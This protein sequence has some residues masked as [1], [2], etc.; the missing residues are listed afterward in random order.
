MPL[1]KG[2]LTY[3]RFFVDPSE[4][5][6]LDLAFV[7]GCLEALAARPFEPLNPDEDV[8]ERIGWCRAGE[9]FETTFGHGDLVWNGHLVLGFRV[10]RWA[11]PSSLV[12]AKTREA[13]S[14]YLERKGRERASKKEKSELR[15]V[16][17]RKL[18]RQ[19]APSTRVF[20][21]ALSLDDGL[22]RFFSHSASR[23]EAM[24]ELFRSTF[25]V[26][27]VP[28]SPY[29]TAARLGLDALTAT[30]HGDAA[31]EALEPSSLSTPPQASAKKGA[32]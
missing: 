32:R 15:E 4:S 5:E 7:D 6:P 26:R 19:L 1:F 28:E 21:L 31:W 27:L 14:A 24:S 25:G 8:A 11:L 29:T 22:V 23:G 9:P 2:T 16:V 13:E 12:K 10:D 20:D 30:R 17:I 3:A 18:R